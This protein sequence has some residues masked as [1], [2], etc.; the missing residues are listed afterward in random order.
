[1]LKKLINWLVSFRLFNKKKKVVISF[2]NE[3][4]DDEKIIRAIY[5]PINLHKNKSKI[6]NNFYK[7]RAGEDEISVNRLDYTTPV[8]LKNLAKAFQNIEG[9]RNYFGFSLLKASEI[10]ENKFRVEFSPI[11][12]PIE[13]PYHADIKINF[14]VEKGVPLDSELSHKI[15]NLTVQSRFYPDPQPDS[16]EW[17]GSELI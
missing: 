17:N 6:N 12:E 11:K 15:K 9:G 8:F 14:T 3:I 4:D 1:M 5:S 10:R 13:N 2:P 7:P 16:I